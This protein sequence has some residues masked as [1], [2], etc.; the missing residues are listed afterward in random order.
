VNALDCVSPQQASWGRG[1][2][3]REGEGVKEEKWWG[4]KPGEIQE[5][6]LK[7]KEGEHIQRLT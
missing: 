7:G 5:K 1:G 3:W 4:R 6:K 2:K